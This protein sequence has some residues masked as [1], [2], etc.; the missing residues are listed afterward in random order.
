MVRLLLATGELLAGGVQGRDPIA[1]RGA[2]MAVRSLP[3][4]RP[5]KE[6]GDRWRHTAERRDVWRRLHL[7]KLAVRA[8]GK[9]ELLDGGFDRHIPAA[10]IAACK[11]MAPHEQQMEDQ[12]GKTEVVVV[13]CPNNSVEG[14]SLQLRRGEGGDTDLAEIVLAIDGNLKAV[15]VDELYCC[16]L[17]NCDAAVVDVSD[18]T[19]VLMDY[20]KGASNVGCNA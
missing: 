13:G 11:G 17:R 15:A 5:L 6:R 2:H 20:T 3:R 1:R 19:I 9:S 18:D 10:R 7:R 14:A 8:I 12:D 4:E 16:V